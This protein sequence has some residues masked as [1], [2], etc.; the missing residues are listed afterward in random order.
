MQR[1]PNASSVD[2]RA[3]SGKVGERIRHW[4][5][6]VSPVPR[7]RTVEE[8]P[9]V[10]TAGWTSVMAGNGT[11]TSKATAFEITRFG[12]T[13]RSCQVEGS[14]APRSRSTESRPASRTLAG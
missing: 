11:I 6:P 12:F 4:E 7:T 8:L 5:D 10:T 13:T 2:G 9:A 3:A 14:A 1:S